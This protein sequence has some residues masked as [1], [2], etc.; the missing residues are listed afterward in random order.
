[1]RPLNVE[2]RIEE[3][4]L[5]GFAPGDRYRIGQAVERE[6]VRLFTEQGVPPSLTQGGEIASMDGGAFNVAPGSKSETIGV[7]VAQ[8]VYRGWS[9]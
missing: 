8:A 1:M 9:R 2:V 6:L 5:H 4:L 3:L 7:Q